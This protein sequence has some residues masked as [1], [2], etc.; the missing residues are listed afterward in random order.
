MIK[1]RLGFFDV[2]F[3]DVSAFSSTENRRK[4]ECWRENLATESTSPS[5]QRP[6]RHAHP[7]FLDVLRACDVV[8]VHF[9]GP[10]ENSTEKP[11]FASFGMAKISCVAA[12]AGRYALR[13]MPDD[14]RHRTSNVLSKMGQKVE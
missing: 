8:Q 11:R 2:K 3:I 4:P 6:P 10:Q 9:L 7:S 1:V 12:E 14:K 13:N 5:T